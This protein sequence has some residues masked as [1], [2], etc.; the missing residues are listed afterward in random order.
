MQDE[1]E[2]EAA[3]T[4]SIQYQK[5][6]IHSLKS[7]SKM[8]WQ[9]TIKHKIT[10]DTGKLKTKN[11]VY[12]VDA[13]S[14]TEVE[15]KL[16]ELSEKIVVGDFTIKPISATDI[17]E[18][19][20]DGTEDNWYK[21]KSEYEFDKKVTDTYLVN[22][23]DAKEAI[24]LFEEHTK[25]Y[26]VDLEILSVAKT[27]IIDVIYYTPTGFDEVYTDTKEWGD[28]EQVTHHFPQLEERVLGDPDLLITYDPDGTY[29]ATNP[30][31]DEDDLFKD[32]F[33]GEGE[34]AP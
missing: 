19:I 24:K 17:I 3:N 28:A 31:I 10:T 32:T 18:I 11:S 30:G 6:A 8:F 12:L 13:V 15:A 29:S 34:E 23:V 1:T 27:K 9:G 33:I 14:H 21:L 22:A 20:G 4:D 26:T 7:K 5:E 16:T 25:E 2:S